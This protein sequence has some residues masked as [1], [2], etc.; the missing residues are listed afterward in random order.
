MKKLWPVLF[1]LLLVSQVVK[2]DGK[3]PNDPNEFLRAKWE[4]VIKDPNDPNELLQVKWDAIV[5]VLETRDINQKAKERIIEKIVSPLFD[6]P[7]MCK[8][9]L[10]RTHWSKLTPAQSD[11]FSRFFVERLKDTY[12][13]KIVLYKDEKVSF[14]PVIK[15]KKTTHIP[16]VMTSNNKKITILYKLRKVGKF[17]KVY[18]VEIQGVSIILTYRSQFNDTLSHST[19][20]DLISQLEKKSTD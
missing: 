16:M 5:K 1:I 17:W 12:R 13:E 2:A 3:D 20:N 11:K 9:T 15:K 8:L 19:I 7:L 6:F 14:K 4:D 18:D 10:G